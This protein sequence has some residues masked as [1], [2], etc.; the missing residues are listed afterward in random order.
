MYLK[1]YMKRSDIRSVAAFL[2]CGS[3]AIGDFDEN[4]A[5]L[6]AMECEKKIADIIVSNINDSKMHD[7]IMSEIFTQ[8]DIFEEMA[9]EL[10]LFT[11]AKLII[12]A[13]DRFENIY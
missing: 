7:E 12:Q 10:G 3:E 8:I 1:N 5:S 4:K 13:M 2:R 9:Y 6:R 11:G